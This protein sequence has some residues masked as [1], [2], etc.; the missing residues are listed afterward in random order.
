M[1]RPH[2][3]RVEHHWRICQFEINGECE[4]KRDAG[5][6]ALM[7]IQPMMLQASVIRRQ[8]YLD[9]G[10]VPEQL[11]TREDTLLF[12]KLA[13]LCP[14]CAV[15][16]CGTVMNS[17]DSI[18]L[19]EVYGENSLVF[20]EATVVL[21]REVLASV[22]NVAW[23]HHQLLIQGL[24]A[25]YIGMARALVRHKRYMSALGNLFISC[26]ISP[27]VFAKALFRSLVR[28]LVERSRS[29]LASRSCSDGNS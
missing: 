26:V 2:L 28:R 13:L 15:S 20:C 25:S 6:W 23:E 14:V 11:R 3:G 18:R 12:F 8:A 27:P 22:K 5:E 29:T 10:G 4:L 17:D 7:R 1:Q 16:G 19:T 21:Y 9:L 24:G